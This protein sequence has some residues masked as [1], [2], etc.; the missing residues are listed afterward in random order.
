MVSALALVMESELDP[1]AASAL[2]MESA[3]AKAAS[4][5]VSGSDREALARAPRLQ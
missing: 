1:A 3:L 2:E 4:D 5:Q